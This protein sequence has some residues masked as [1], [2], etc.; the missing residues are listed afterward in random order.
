[1]V[2]VTVFKPDSIEQKKTTKL[3]I[4]SAASRRIP[5]PYLLEER[6]MMKSCPQYQKQ[7]HPIK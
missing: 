5:Q 7:W 3:A 6:S 2:C 4:S 1:M